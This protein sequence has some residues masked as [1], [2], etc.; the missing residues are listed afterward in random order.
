MNPLR[1]RARIRN[2]LGHELDLT[3]R[4]DDDGLGTLT[5]ALDEDLLQIVASDIGLDLVDDDGKARAFLAPGVPGDVY[6]IIV[7]RETGLRRPKW[8]RIFGGVLDIPFSIDIDRKDGVVSL[9]AFAYGK[10]LEQASAETIRRTVT[11]RTG[12]VSAS[13]AVVTVDDTTDLR[14]GDDIQLATAAVEESQRIFS[15]DGPTQV[16]TV[17]TWTNA[18]TNAPLE[19]LTPYERDR[20]IE[21]LAGQL[22]TTG[23]IADYEVSID[24]EISG[25]PVATDMSRAGTFGGSGLPAL[26]PRS[27]TDVDG[28]IKIRY[29]SGNAKSAP[30]ARD[31]FH[32]DGGANTGI[33]DWQP[34]VLTEP[35]LV[36]LEERAGNDDGTIAPD[37]ASGN[38]YQYSLF[39]EF[40]ADDP[41]DHVNLRLRRDGSNLAII[42]SYDTGGGA[43]HTKKSLEYDPVNLG[44]WTSYRRSPGDAVTGDLEKIEFY[45]A[46]TAAQTDIVGNAVGAFRHLRCVR[47]LGLMAAYNGSTTLDLYDLASKTKVRTLTAPTGLATWTLRAWDTWLAGLA[48]IGA[49]WFVVI[50][51]TR[52]WAEIARYKVGAPGTNQ[53]YLAVFRDEERG[54]NLAVGFAGSSYFVLGLAFEGVLPYANFEGMSCAKAL[55]D[56]AVCAGAYLR[57]DEHRI[58]G[59]LSRILAPAG[60][61]KE[62]GTPL[63]W[64]ST[65]FGE[66]YVR[67]VVVTGKDADGNDVKEIAGA[68]GESQYQIEI[69]S[70]LIST[71]GVAFAVG[72]QYFGLFGT[73]RPLEEL[74]IEE[75]AGGALAALD[76]VRLEGRT[77]VV[78]EAE[79]HL[80]DREQDLV[81]L[82]VD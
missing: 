21:W 43:G 51:D 33:L 37:Y 58:G 31:G 10:L 65:P 79:T 22:F 19:L 12:T 18:F 2:P 16:T 6:E 41:D 28:E 49:A 38:E 4:I 17:K 64:S 69:S 42:D 63:E 54:R 20:S 81:L 13:S 59:L 30:N 76:S 29:A 15:V 23:G 24:H 48:Q 34:Y 77:Y 57:V 73:P 8:R 9:T 70:Q 56:L 53:P 61:P 27:I 39:A 32:D 52:T 72:Q 66:R 60:T 3:D 35:A 11:G 36:D 5:D 74:T 71:A 25:T 50:W 47:S 1:F 55:A 46:G 82:G 80:A 40:V 67:Q 78:L 75:P 68:T 62:I 45:D 44:V 26:V 14:V 7:E